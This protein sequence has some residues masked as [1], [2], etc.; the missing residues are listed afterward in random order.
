MRSRRLGRVLDEGR[1]PAPRPRAAIELS[2]RRRR[3][4]HLLQLRDNGTILSRIEILR[5]AAPG[6]PFSTVPNVR[7]G[8]ESLL[9]LSSW[10]KVEKVL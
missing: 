10:R 2:L 4:S 9:H 3:Q 1:G 7:P 8:G 5:A 6:Q